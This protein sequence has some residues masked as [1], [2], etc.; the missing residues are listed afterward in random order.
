LPDAIADECVTP[1]VEGLLKAGGKLVSLTPAHVEL[2][3]LY[4]K[5][6][7][8]ASVAD[9]FALSFSK[10]EGYTLLSGDKKLREAAKKEKVPVHGVLWLLDELISEE[11]LAKPDAIVALKKMQENGARLPAVECEKRIK[12]WGR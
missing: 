10:A 5:Q 12:R 6:Y 1:T 11:L 9:L 8:G 3:D 2:V 7:R 4:A